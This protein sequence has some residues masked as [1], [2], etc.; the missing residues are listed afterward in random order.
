[1][2]LSI[3]IP[4]KNRQQVLLES[5]EYALRAIENFEAE[6]IVVN[7]GDAIHNLPENDKLRLLDNNRQGA[8]KAR[9]MGGREAKYPL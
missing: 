5:I 1:M 3:I 2:Q 6:I 8:S 7:D 9:N 4:T